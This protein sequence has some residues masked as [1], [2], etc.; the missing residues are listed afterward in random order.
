MS[1]SNPVALR[2]MARY[3]GGIVSRQQ[4]LKAGLAPDIIR[5]KV[6]YGRWRSIYRGVYATFTG[7]LGRH[8]QLWAAVL[9]A[10]AG[11][12]L[13]HETAAELQGLLDKPAPLI[14]LMVPGERRVRQVPGV[15]IHT[16]ARV[17]GARFPL[18]TL[19]QTWVEDTILDLTD[20]ADNFD[21]VCG[22]VT[23]AFGRRLTGEGA[24]RATMGQR[25][26][27]RW[28]SELDEIIT[29]A[30]GGAHSVLEFRYDRDVE[31]AHGLP[32]ARRQVPF[33]KPDGRRGFRDRFY[34]AYGLVVELDGKEAHPEENRRTDVG[35]DN[36]ATATG[37]ST[38][39]YGWED[40]T[41]KS[42][43]TAAQV[44]DSLTARG[45]VGRLN[46]CS[47]SCRAS[48]ATRRPPHANLAAARPS[49]P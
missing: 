10:G 33:K 42:C 31:R 21:D 47:P 23:K 15:V 11:A 44:A 38:L 6:R 8:A 41:R 1:R 45:W 30:A 49:R 26:R 16:S 3:Q 18:G 5:S 19:P 20:A 36:A 32:S 29:A 2:E 7:P 28:R 14:H 9:Y 35:R 40:V 46:P 13:S 25:G 39:R 43:G 17:S 34:Q 37:G 22:W 27:L 24:L 12:V 4:A 48:T